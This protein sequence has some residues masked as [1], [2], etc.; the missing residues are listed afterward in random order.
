[1]PAR[2]ELIAV[3]AG[4]CLGTLARAAVG[5]LLPTPWGTLAVNVFGAF[6]LGVVVTRSPRFWGTG[7]CGALTTFSTLQVE[8]LQL[9]RGWAVLYLVGSVVLGYAAVDL[10]RRV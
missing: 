4:G 5:E 3:F 7:F 8:A 1:V 10:G 6:L 9:A 2:S